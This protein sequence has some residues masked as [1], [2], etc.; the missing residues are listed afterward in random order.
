MGRLKHLSR[1]GIVRIEC[2][3]RTDGSGLNEINQID[4]NPILIGILRQ[5]SG[6]KT[7]KQFVD[8][9]FMVGFHRLDDDVN[10]IQGFWVDCKYGMREPEKGSQPSWQSRLMGII[11]LKESRD[12]D[13]QKENFEW[14]G[15][16]NEFIMGAGKIWTEAQGKLGY[17]YEKAIWD[18]EPGRLGATP[19]RERN[20]I[21]KI[22][23]AYGGFRTALAW[24]VYCCGIPQFDGMGKMIWDNKSP[25]R[26]YVTCDKKPSQ[27]AKHFNAILADEIFKDLEQ[28]KEDEIKTNLQTY[29]GVMIHIKPRYNEIQNQTEDNE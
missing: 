17:G 9:Y 11:D 22:F 26:Q 10:D 5:A 16:V 8:H 14:I 25:H 18:D 6:I 28:N 1:Y 7:I 3:F 13:K 23:Q 27:F 15:Y 2:R 12:K 4:V 21:G 29:F 20:E 24:Y 19:K